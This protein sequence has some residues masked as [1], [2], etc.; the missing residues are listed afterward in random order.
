MGPLFSPEKNH[1]MLRRPQFCIEQVSAILWGQLLRIGPIAIRTKHQKTADVW[2]KDVWDFQ[3]FSHTSLELRFSLGN[4]GKDGM[5]LNSQTWPGTPR[6]PSPRHLRPPE[7][8][9]SS[10]R[11]RLVWMPRRPALKSPAK[12]ASRSA[13]GRPVQMPRQPRNDLQSAGSKIRDNAQ[14]VKCKP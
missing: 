8:R 7:S 14:T 9:L 11:P 1:K 2:K 10:P 6:R 13:P 12:I 3:T 5:N 4:E